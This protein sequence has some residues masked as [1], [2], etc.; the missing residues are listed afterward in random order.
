MTQAPAAV[1]K[2]PAVSPQPPRA[3]ARKAPSAG[4]KATGLNVIPVTGAGTRAATRGDGEVLEVGYGISVYPPRGE[5]GRW[6]AAW[7]EN[8]QRRQC[9]SV[10]KE[11]FTEKLEKAGQRL[12]TGASNMTRPGADLIAHY[13]DPTVSRSR[14]GGRAGTPTASSGCA[15][16]SPPR[17]SRRSPARKSPSRT[18]RRS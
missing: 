3:K 7:H 16:G 13:L 18:R 2:I 15:G 8:G 5:G 4:P 10:S 11:A 9:E 6:R 12:A 1:F 17:S 14:S